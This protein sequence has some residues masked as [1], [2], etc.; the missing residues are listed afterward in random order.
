MG[1]IWLEPLSATQAI[2]PLTEA[3]RVRIGRIRMKGGGA[4]LYVLPRRRQSEIAQHMQA[5]TKIVLEEGRPPDAYAAVAFWINPDAPGRCE[6]NIGFLSRHD[7]LPL[8][9]LSRVAAAYLGDM[10]PVARGAQHAVE[11]LGYTPE[12]WEPEPA[13]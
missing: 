3:A 7:A 13:A 10:S 11:H 2:R 1:A 4:D 8:P 12:D 5:W 9:V 6:Y